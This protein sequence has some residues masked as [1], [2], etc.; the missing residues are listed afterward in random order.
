LDAWRGAHQATRSQRVVTARGGAA[1]RI[2]ARR[3]TT[4]SNCTELALRLPASRYYLPLRA[5]CYRRCAPRCRYNADLRCAG[6]RCG[7]AGRI[8]MPLHCCRCHLHAPRRDT[9]YWD[10]LTP[11]RTLALTRDCLVSHY[12]GRFTALRPACA[13]LRCLACTLPLRRRARRRW[14]SRRTI[15]TARMA[16]RALAGSRGIARGRAYARLQ[17]S[18]VPYLCA[19]NRARLRTPSRVRGLAQHHRVRIFW[20]AHGLPGCAAHWKIAPRCCAHLSLLTHTRDLSSRAAQ[21]RCSRIACT[22]R[23]LYLSSACMRYNAHCR[24]ATAPGAPLSSWA[25]CAGSAGRA[26][27]LT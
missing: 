9:A 15:A 2:D 22:H 6:E 20:D 26:A 27:P 12:V 24:A 11:H 21:R 19:H 1:R 23:A 17:A 3:G 18:R 5:H 10:H 14:T 13:I 7:A 4:R 16:D 8:A 25:C